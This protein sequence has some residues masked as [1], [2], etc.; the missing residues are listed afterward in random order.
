MKIID[1][2]QRSPEWYV[3]RNGGITASIPSTILG[4]NP[5]KT[6]WRLWAEM[7]GKVEPEDL[8][9]SPVVQRGVR[10]EDL[11]RVEFERRHDEIL[12]PICGEHDTDSDM[13]A[14][15]D[16]ISS[17]GAPVELKCPHPTTM[18][19][20]LTE[21]E[22]S[23][24]YQMYWTQVQ[25]Q[26]YVAGAMEGFL[27]FYCDE[28]VDGYAD[29]ADEHGV[30]WVE[31]RIVRDDAFIENELLPANRAFLTLVREGKAPPK[32]PERDIYVPEAADFG[33]WSTHAESW[34]RKREIIDRL[35]KDMAALKD[36]QKADEKAMIGLM[37]E[38]AHAEACDV[39]ITRF[40]RQ[41][42]ID[43]KKILEEKLPGMD[44]TQ[45]DAYRKKGTPQVR[46]CAVTEKDAS[47]S[48][49]E[50]TSSSAHTIA[51]AQSAPELDKE[52]VYSW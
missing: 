23:E 42:A 29:A 30:I 31:F 18:A 11:A 17:R 47:L 44:A 10:K 46:I 15:C 20:V 45:Q 37:G 24:P 12:L 19:A 1:I 5:H 28:P 7:T 32:D 25:H 8:S 39:R 40:V 43:Y 6:P 38:F 21:R 36:A 9:R 13:K 41:G 3:W 16:G 50:Q 4:R 2:Q 51:Q 27:G 33:A 35:A 14:S 49:R 34:L 26:I 48:E 22:R 52:G